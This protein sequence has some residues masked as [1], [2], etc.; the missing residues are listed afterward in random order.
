MRRAEN[1]TGLFA[2]R[3]KHTGRIFRVGAGG[4]GSIRAPAA[5]YFSPGA[6]VFSVD[7]AHGFYYNK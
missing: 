7:K 1:L 3:R 2:I 4:R 6:P 5:N